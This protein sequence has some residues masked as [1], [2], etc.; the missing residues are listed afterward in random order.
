MNHWLLKAEPSEY[1]WDD[2]VRDGRAVWDGVTNALAQK[3]LRAVQAGD[4]VFVYH[5]ATERRIVGIARVTRAPFI[6]PK[7]P[8]GRLVVIEIEPVS[9][10]DEPIPLEAMRADTALA[11]WEL[12]RLPRLS[13]MPVPEAIWRRLLKGDSRR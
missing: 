12:L 7:H 9:A 3:H 4:D 1:S 11:G 6:D 13:V 5:T 2:L 10:L 8:G